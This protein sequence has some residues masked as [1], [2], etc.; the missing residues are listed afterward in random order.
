[1]KGWSRAKKEA[2]MRADFAALRAL[3]RRSGKK[4]A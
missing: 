1:V 2:L 3:S 4:D